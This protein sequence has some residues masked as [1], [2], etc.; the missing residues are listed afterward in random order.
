MTRTTVEGHSVFENSVSENSLIESKELVLT[1]M[2]N[3]QY[4]TSQYNLINGYYR[5][6]AATETQPNQRLHFLH[7]NGFAAMTLGAIAAQMPKAW[8]I[9]LTDVPGHG[10]SSQPNHRMPNWQAMADEI[11]DAIYHQADVEKKGPLIGIGHSMG[12]ILTL[13]AAYK[14]PDLFSKI[15]LLDPVLF[16]TEIL[17]AQHFMRATGIWKSR[18][19]VRAVS[20]RQKTWPNKEAMTNY[21]KTKNLYKLWHPQILLDY[22]NYASK[23]NSFQ[24]RELLCNPR[25]EGAIFGSYPRGLWKAIRKLNVP[26]HLI[27]A[28]Q[29][30]SFIPKSAK[31]AAKVNKLIQWQTFGQSHCFPM[32]QPFETAKV[33]KELLQR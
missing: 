22:V 2:S 3:W 33:I 1:D 15:I 30:Y 25:W 9:W 20:N 8:D 32:E 29:T 19:L 26:A 27:I 7:G 13:Y 18:A 23:E 24:E 5:K 17:I 14:Y 10:H 28:E 4:K 12:G 31:K 21:L 16:K 11:A 6:G